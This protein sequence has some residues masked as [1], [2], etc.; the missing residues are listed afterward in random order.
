MTEVH[1]ETYSTMILWIALAVAFVALGADLLLSTWRRTPP[2]LRGDWWL[3]FESGFRA[4][5]ERGAK[6]AGENRP[7]THDRKS[8]P[9]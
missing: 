8:P 4:Y 6:A 3:R 7:R 9:Q 2:E 1:F 5:A